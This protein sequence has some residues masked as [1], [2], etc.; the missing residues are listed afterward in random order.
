VS[1]NT[2]RSCYVCGS[3]NIPQSFTFNADYEVLKDKDDH[4]KVKIPKTS[5]KHA[6]QLFSFK[7]KEI[8]PQAHGFVSFCI[9]CLVKLIEE[10][11]VLKREKEKCNLCGKKFDDEHEDEGEVVKP[12]GEGY[13]GYGSKHDMELHD[14]LNLAPGWYCYKCLDKEVDAGR[15]TLLRDFMG[16]MEDAR[17]RANA[18]QADYFNT[19][20][21][22]EAE[23]ILRAMKFLED[24]GTAEVARVLSRDD[25]ITILWS[26]KSRDE[27]LLND[28]IT[29]E[30]RL[31]QILP[32]LSFTSPEL[33]EIVK[34]RA[35]EWSTH[36]GGKDLAIKN[37]NKFLAALKEKNVKTTEIYDFLLTLSRQCQEELNIKQINGLTRGI[38]LHDASPR[39]SITVLDD[40]SI[41]LH[42][43]EEMKIMK[44]IREW[45]WRPKMEEVIEEIKK[46]QN[47]T[48]P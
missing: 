27:Y 33:E 39:L 22:E 1:G 24:V 46:K 21:K 36:S 16:E 25:G 38:E 6:D 42:N 13:L 48:I 14:F 8:Y 35:S 26:E 5:Q 2:D 47:L 23:E 34:L 28:L 4:Y 3:T 30:V 9:P 20:T 32:L 44:I 18:L 12:S 29:S 45:P 40:L 41:I 43:N 17:T 10:G 37:H 31:D 19:C 7:L 11:K 15:T